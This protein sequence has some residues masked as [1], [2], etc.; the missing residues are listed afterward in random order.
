MAQIPGDKS[1]Y[2]FL[3]LSPLF[4]FILANVSYDSV[5]SG[6]KLRD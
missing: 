3:L 4:P 5:A 6:A 2:L 1:L